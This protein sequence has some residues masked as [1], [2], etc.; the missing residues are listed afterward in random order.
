[1]ANAISLW[2]TFL[3]FHEATIRQEVQNALER[4]Q[5]KGMLASKIETVDK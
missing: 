3:E 5:I 2:E 4:T 1:M